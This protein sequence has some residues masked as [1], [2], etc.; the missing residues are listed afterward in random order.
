MKCTKCGKEYPSHYHFVNESICIS[1]FE[2]L[3]PAEKKRIQ[4]DVESMT[5]ES[6]APRTILGKPLICPVCGHNEF[7]RR[8]TLMNTPGMT[9]FGVEWANKRADN[10]ICDACGYIYWFFKE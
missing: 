8:Q 5:V 2:N 1:C 6:A 10:L 7:W 4:D 3:S 9:F